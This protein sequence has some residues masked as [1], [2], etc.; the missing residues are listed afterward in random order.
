MTRLARLADRFRRS[1]FARQRWPQPFSPLEGKLI[2]WGMNTTAAPLIRD[3]G[4]GKG[5]WR[6]ARR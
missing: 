5:R 1:A 6:W 2:G 3:F 4:K